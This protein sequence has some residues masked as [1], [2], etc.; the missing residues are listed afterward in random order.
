MAQPTSTVLL[1]T[2]T[3]LAL[4]TGLAHAQEYDAPAPAEGPETIVG[5]SLETRQTLIGLVAYAEDRGLPEGQS[6]IGMK[7]QILL[8]RAHASPGVIDGYGGENT[9][10]ALR[11]FEELN[12]FPVD[13]VLDPDTWEAL[14]SDASPTTQIYEITGEDLEHPFE[15]L[16]EDYAEL[17][18]LD[19][20]G[21]ES[22]TEMLSERFHMD[23]DLLKALNPGAAFDRAGERILV[24]DPAG[25]PPADRVVRIVADR[26]AAKLSAFDAD[27]NLVV[28]YPATIGSRDTPSPSG[29]FEVTAIAPD[30]VYYYRPD[31]NFQQGDNDEPLELPPGPNNPVG[32]R[33]IDLSKDTYGIHGT[34]EPAEIDKTFSHGCVRLT[35]WDVEELAE[36]VEVGAT[37]EFVK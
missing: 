18:A 11:V 12:G 34:A 35:N 3:A 20:L 30:P 17:A 10:K 37:V 4:C 1:R 28:A 16:P 24:A 27:G 19:R 31:E 14:S 5:E 25:A 7:L 32:T 23:V 33:W 15:P 2:F 8:D 9:A 26:S 29:T 21:W 6:L 36:L 22:P 13:G